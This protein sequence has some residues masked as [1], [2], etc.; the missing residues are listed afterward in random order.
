MPDKIEIK[1]DQA[2][3]PALII[4]VCM[5]GFL[6]TIPMLLLWTTELTYMSG[7]WYKNFILITSLLTWVSLAG[8]CYMK[9]W[10][11]VVYAIV[12]TSTQIILLRYNVM[13]SYTS[14]IVPTIVLFTMLFYFRKMT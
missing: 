1:Q 7:Q 14:L 8:V 12:I 11:A 13:W 5:L 3:T 6:G 4:A 9:K 10:A 2:S